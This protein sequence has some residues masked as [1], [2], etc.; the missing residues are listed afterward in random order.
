MMAGPAHSGEP[1]DSDPTALEVPAAAGVL[2]A[3]VVD[4]HTDIRELLRIQLDEQPDV[5]VVGVASDGVE[6]IAMAE[7]LR[8]DVLLLDLGMP[9]LSGLDAL[10]RLREVSPLTKI[11][12]ISG[13]E[14]G[15]QARDA[16]AAGV[17]AY[18]EKGLNMGLVDVIRAV[19]A[20]DDVAD[21]D[22][23]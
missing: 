20:S 17:D 5:T 19:C 3:L 4:D 23:A 7:E 9:R 14:E 22:P 12:A 2:R 1:N 8:P 10:P 13:F 6:A 18:V 11:V 15:S 16:R 21:L